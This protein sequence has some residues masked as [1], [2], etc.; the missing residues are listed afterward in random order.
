MASAPKG[1]LGYTEGTTPDMKFA[2]PKHVEPLRQKVL[3]FV[4]TKVYALERELERL[5]KHGGGMGVGG[6]KEG[7]SEAAR[8]LKKL[9]DEAKAAGLWALGHP[10][11]IGGG[12]M[13]FMDYIYVNEVQGRSELAQTALGT[14]SLQDS[15][16]LY[17]HGSAELKAKY[18]ERLVSAEIYPS[19]AMTEPDVPSSDPTQLQT[20]ARL[21]GNE[22]VI[23]GR[24]W[25]TSNAMNAEYTSVFV[26]TEFDEN[27]PAHASFSVILVPTSTKGYNI[28]RSVHVL[29]AHGGDHSEVVYDN[30]RVPASNIIGKRGQGFMIAQ[31]RLGP[32]RIFH[33]MR[34]IG[35]MQR[36]FDLMCE[37]L[38]ERKVRGGGYLG[39]VGLMQEQHL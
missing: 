3:E 26:R 22:W 18:L 20:Y 1:R 38:A 2:V 32:G 17:R 16:M 5:G 33:C 9:Q 27:V 31:E 25:W 34:W 15:L 29:G 14:H 36:A 7:T 10:K 35:Q 12:N 8:A 37:R 11:E 28:Q 13:P 4:E 30:V 6:L 24:K 23:N 21:E 19:F 39:D